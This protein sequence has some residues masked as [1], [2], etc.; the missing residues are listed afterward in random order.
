MCLFLF[1]IVTLPLINIAKFKNMFDITLCVCVCV[2]VNILLILC[3]NF[4]VG[5]TTAPTSVIINMKYFIFFMTCI[6]FNKSWSWLK[7][8]GHLFEVYLQWRRVQ[9]LETPPWRWRT[10]IDKLTTGL[11]LDVV[12]VSSPNMFIIYLFFG[13]KIKKK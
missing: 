11:Q 2:C 6:L 10:Y 5:M 1:D 7:L 8:W 12:K 3:Y 4:K 9:R 13:T